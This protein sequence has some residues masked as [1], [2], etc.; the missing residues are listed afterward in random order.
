VSRQTAARDSGAGALPRGRDGLVQRPGQIAGLREEGSAEEKEGS[1]AMAWAA[2]AKERCWVAGAKEGCW[3]AGAREGCWVAGR[4][5]L[6]DPRPAV[7]AISAVCALTEIG[8][9]PTVVAPAVGY[10]RRL[11]RARVE[12]VETRR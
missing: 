5:R 2:A 3:V 12:A 1:E 6:L 9:R 7:S 11:L 10:V 8:T 4:E